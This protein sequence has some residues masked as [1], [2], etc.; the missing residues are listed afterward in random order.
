MARVL[1]IKPISQYC[2][3]IAPNLGLGYLASTLR[4]GG[5]DVTFLDCDKER[6]DLE[7][8]AAHMSGKDY[9]VVGFQ[10]YTNGLHTTKRQLEI[11]RQYVKDALIVIGGPHATGDPNQ[12]LAF[13][14]DADIAVLGEAEGI[15]CEIAGLRKADLKNIAALKKISN[16]AYRD[17]AGKVCVNPITNI[18]DLDK[19]PMPAW[20]LMDPR[21]YPDAPHGT[22]ARAFPIA[23]IVTSRGCPYSCTFCASFTMHG[24]KMRRRS[25]ESVLDE[26]AFLNAKYGVKEFQIEDDNFT[27]GKEYAKEVLSGIIERGF[28]IWIS[29]P[30]G[31]R[32]DSLDEELLRLMERAGCYSLSIGVE[33]GSDRILK[34]LQKN[35]TTKEIEDKARLVKRYTKI[36]MTGFFLI[37]HP[38]ET[39]EDIMKSIDFAVRLPLDGASFSP[40]MP[41]PGSRIYDEW[42]ERVDFGRVDW[43]KF[44]YYQFIDSVSGIEIKKLERYLKKANIRFY[45]RPRIWLGLL[46]DVRTPYQLKVL[47]DRARKILIG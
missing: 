33:S 38:E 1:L 37:G 29:L 20:D 8:F 41:L 24:R 16:I 30:N 18:E 3:T 43:N 35:L 26:I 13:L 47:L 22:F 11:V 46:N 32:I 2:Y 34:M 45:I 31:I 10:L 12:A 39:E 19:I 5:H 25:C 4:H 36:R 28:K 23:P 40:L 17:L 6:F 27:M 9:D 14:K 7:K 15:I 42:K 21:S 44:L